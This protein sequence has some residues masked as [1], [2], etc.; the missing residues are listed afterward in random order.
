MARFADAALD[1]VCAWVHVYLR[2]SKAEGRQALTG[3][4]EVSRPDAQILD[5]DLR[6]PRGTFRSWRSI[7]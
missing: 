1:E 4:G 3:A 5:S 7:R 2:L 6:N